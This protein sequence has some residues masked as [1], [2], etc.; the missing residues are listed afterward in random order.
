MY[1][2]RRS[3]EEVRK[4]GL[5]DDCGKRAKEPYTGLNPSGNLREGYY[6]VCFSCR[7]W[8]Y[9]KYKK[10]V[11]ERCGFIPEHRVQLDV[12]HI[13]GDHINNNPSN[14]QTLCANCHRLKTMLNGDGVWGRYVP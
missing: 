5:C 6:P 12:D 3:Y 9:R 10:E 14:L 4:P 1:R 11:C 7:R 13:D 8:P 2:K